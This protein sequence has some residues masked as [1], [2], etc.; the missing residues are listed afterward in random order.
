M[1]TNGRITRS[2]KLCRR[3]SSRFSKLILAA[4]VVVVVLLIMETTMPSTDLTPN[5]IRVLIPTMPRKIRTTMENSLVPCLTE[6][7]L[8]SR[9][10]ATTQWPYTDEFRSRNKKC[11]NLTGDTLVGE[12]LT[13]YAGEVKG[14]LTF[15]LSNNQS[16]DSSV[17]FPNRVSLHFDQ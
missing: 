15:E 7:K 8:D 4:V 17:I 10:E 16:S 1:M 3:K 11:L 14:K 5:L 2:L 9:E 13:V 6:A 12:F